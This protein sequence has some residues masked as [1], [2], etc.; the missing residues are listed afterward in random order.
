MDVDSLSKEVKEWKTSN[1]SH[2]ELVGFDA[3]LRRLNFQGQNTDTTFYVEVAPDDSPAKWHVWSESESVLLKLHPSIESVT[4]GKVMSLSDILTCC[5]KDIEQDKKDQDAEVEEEEDDEDDDDENDDYYIESEEFMDD[6]QATINTGKEEGS[7][8]DMDDEP[9]FFG[10]MNTATSTAIQRL[11][12]D[13][14]NILKVGPEYGIVANP[15]GD[16]LFMWD[17]KLTDVPTDSRL[18]KDLQQ[19]STKY[20]QEPVVTLDMQFSQDY[21]FAPPFIR[22]IR[23]RFKFLTGHVTIGGSICMEMLTKSGWVP[24]N[25]IESILVQVRAEIM[26]DPNASLDSSRPNDAYTEREARDA[27]NRMVSRYGWNK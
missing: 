18:G 1:N 12:R 15:R 9:G 24:S 19:Y 26:S 6:I 27:F 5:S 8:V 4:S 7:D 25:D 11:R 17:V 13:L 3:S 22:V 10:P 23:P 14:K 21:P 2:L 16:N 20:K